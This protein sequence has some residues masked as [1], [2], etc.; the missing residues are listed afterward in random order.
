V[1]P[2]P[3]QDC[4]CLGFVWMAIVAT[5]LAMQAIAPPALRGSAPM[6]R[7]T[8]K[9]TLAMPLGEHVTE[10]V[11]ASCKLERIAD[12]PVLFASQ[13]F[14]WTTFVVLRIALIHVSR[15]VSTMHTEEYASTFP[16]DLTTL[17]ALP[18]ATYVMAWEIANYRMA[19][20]AHCPVNVYQVFV[21]KARV[22]T[23]HA[24]QAIVQT[25]PRELVPMLPSMSQ[26]RELATCLHNV[27]MVAA[28]AK[29]EMVSFVRC[30]M[31]VCLG[32]VI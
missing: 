17:N 18:L 30:P 24:M 10:Q 25:A 1:A 14:A 4:V 8:C 22:A 21:W 3:I 7:S 27:A 16:Q 23:Q 31:N 26:I 32:R 15:V 2:A 29:K 19:R 13:A 12:F 5:Q 6:L 9:T 20:T 11:S 28:F